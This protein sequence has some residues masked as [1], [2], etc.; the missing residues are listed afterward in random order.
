[1]TTDGKEP[2]HSPVARVN[3]SDF[4]DHIATADAE[5]RRQWLYP[6]KPRG[7][8]YR[9]RTWLTW[10]LLAVMFGG[11]FVKINGNPLLM[12]NVV[13]RKFAVLGVIFWPQDNLVFALGF[14]LFLTGIAVF[15]AAFGR[16]WCG[17]T[18]PQTVLME[19]VFRKLEYLIEGDSH[20]QRAMDRGPW[21]TSK[22]ARKALKHGIFFALSFIIGNTLLA[23]IIGIDA[24]KQLVTDDPRNHMTGLAFM[25]IFTLVFYGIFARFR[26]QACTFICPYGRFQSTLLD[27]NSIVVAYDYRRGEKREHLRRAES[28][29]QRQ[30]RGLGDCIDCFQCVT[31]CPTGIDIRNGTQM[32]CVSCTA[33]I[34]AC[35]GVMTK[36]GRPKGL[37]RYASL[38]G[39]EKGEPVRVTP[40]IIGYCTVLLVLGI[41][42]AALLLTRSDVDATLLRAP[43]GL[44]QQTPD[45]KIS[46]LY[47]LKLTNK[48]HH[49]MPAELRL[50]GIE[51]TL[52]VLGGELNLHPEQQTEASVLI[53]IPPAK[54]A[55]GNT[56]VSVGLHV[57]GK[58]IDTIKTVFIG[59]RH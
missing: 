37:I 5:G 30:T 2:G 21:T 58:K 24:L 35:D 6:R 8:F 36:I 46:N 29:N 23:Y 19:M 27:E 20:Q 43:G 52:T 7:R 47:L 45:G 3:W 40:R 39:I 22:V 56:P 25:G 4:R 38:N 11:P 49:R 31:V 51:G 12:I 57:A 1:M 41:G 16:L 9:A 33:C 13:E 44:F 59:P 18:C 53:E 48:T 15:T 26:E 50:E 28:R 54:L 10:L 42:L 32:E 34:D 14:L 17:W 55:S